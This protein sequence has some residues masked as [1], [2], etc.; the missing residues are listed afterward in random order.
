MDTMRP[1]ALEQMKA[2]RLMNRIDQKY[3]AAT[4]LL[5]ELLQQVADH[6][7]VQRI[8]GVALAPYHTLYFDTPSLDM[9][10]AHHN[11]KL[12]RLKLRVRRYRSTD[13]TFFE[14]KQKDNK[15]HT[16][17]TRISVDA[18]QFDHCLQLPEVQQFVAT[19][20]PFSISTL[21]PQVENHFERITLVNNQM[22]ER[23]TIDTDITF[24]NHTTN[25]DANIN[26]LMVIEVKHEVGTPTSAIEHALHQL[27][28]LPRRMSKYCIGTAITYPNIKHNR[29]KPK[30]LYI[31]KLALI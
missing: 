2:V 31:D 17:K 18:T 5:P 3:M 6:Y 13:T 28:I 7:Y 12:N 1:I 21:Q 16:H 10:V 25:I 11:Q 22:T 19:N 29:F 20:T 15:K 26:H 23:I 27:H 24:H 9:Y 4:Y 14:L 8:D 30:L